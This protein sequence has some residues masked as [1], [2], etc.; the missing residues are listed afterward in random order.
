MK[1]TMNML[2]IRSDILQNEKNGKNLSAAK[3]NKNVTEKFE[4]LSDLCTKFDK[5]SG[6]ERKKHLIRYLKSFAH[7]DAIPENYYE[8][9]KMITNKSNGTFERVKW[10]FSRGPFPKMRFFCDYL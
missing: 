3:R 10:I 4:I 7:R 6:E 8:T 2:L 1:N 9:L 5:Y